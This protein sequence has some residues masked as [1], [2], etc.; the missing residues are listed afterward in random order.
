MSNQSQGITVNGLSDTTVTGTKGSWIKVSGA[1][2]TQGAKTLTVKAC[3]KSGAVIKVC[4]G[5]PSGDVITYAEIKAGTTP[6]EITVPVVNSVSGS[7]DICFLFSGD[8]TF[9]SWSFS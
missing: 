6:E 2:F 7:K 8:I 4:T 5:G 1:N 9:D 3:S